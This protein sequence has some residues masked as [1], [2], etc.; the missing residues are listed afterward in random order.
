MPD[1]MINICQ[2][3]T[4]RWQL[5]YDKDPNNRRDP[6]AV[7]QKWFSDNGGCVNPNVKPTADVLV[8]IAGTINDPDWH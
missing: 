7:V 6:P 8:W 1:Y 2:W 5:W 3:A 4:A